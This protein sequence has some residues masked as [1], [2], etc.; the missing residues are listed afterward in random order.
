[1]YMCTHIV[2]T[3]TYM[4][5]IYIYIY[6]YTCVCV[7]II[8]IHIYIYMHAYTLYYMCTGAGVMAISNT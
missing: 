3:H 2:K 4:P 7:C 1:M 8:R 6:T 5:H